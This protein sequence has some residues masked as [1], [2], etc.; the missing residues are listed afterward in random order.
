MK[1]ISFSFHVFINIVFT[2]LKFQ[3][4]KFNSVQ[5]IIICYFEFH[6]VPL[7]QNYHSIMIFNQQ[8]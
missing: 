6:F 7:Q 3:L 1:I 5:R 2:N 4:Q 8:K